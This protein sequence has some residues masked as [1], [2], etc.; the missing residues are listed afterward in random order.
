MWGRIRT[1][2]SK[3]GALSP[4]R[5]CSTARLPP[6]NRRP[7][8]FAPPPHDGFAILASAHTDALARNSTNDRRRV[9]RPG[10]EGGQVAILRLHAASTGHVTSAAYSCVRGGR[11]TQLQYFL[12][13]SL[14]TSENSVKA[15]FSGIA[16]LP[17]RPGP[18]GLHFEGGQ[19]VR[20][21]L[22]SYVRKTAPL[23][24]LT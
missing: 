18:E 16:H 3:G 19:Y 1:L 6:I 14:R 5:C 20:K 17:H 21:V 8:G 11:I 7:L 10:L 22:E 13:L 23:I 2:P 12:Q 24:V 15:K 4:R 9:A